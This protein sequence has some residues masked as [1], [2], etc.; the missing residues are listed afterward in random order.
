[1]LDRR[2][3]PNRS[4]LTLESVKSS[5]IT[6]ERDTSNSSHT[7]VITLIVGNWT[8]ACGFLIVHTCHF[9]VMPIFPRFLSPS[10]PGAVFQL[11]PYPP[12][13]GVLLTLKARK[14]HPPACPASLAYGS[15]TDCDVHRKSLL[16]FHK[17]QHHSWQSKWPFYW[18]V[19]CNKVQ[20]QIRASEWRLGHSKET[21]G[22]GCKLSRNIF[23]RLAGTYI[24]MHMTGNTVESFLWNGGTRFISRHVNAHQFLPT[25][26]QLTDHLHACVTSRSYPAFSNTFFF[27][28]EKLV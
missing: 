10:P 15:A 19:P 26:L 21:P 11:S 4:A 18:Y 17:E 2:P 22:E 27:Y 23:H 3:T 16:V 24:H 12:T 28:P 20:M 13:W 7:P 1:M 14:F 9:P 6:L 25:V 8:P 5:I